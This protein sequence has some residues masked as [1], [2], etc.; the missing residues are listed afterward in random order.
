MT[1]HITTLHH[2]LLSIPMAMTVTSP[3]TPSHL[4]RKRGI[5]QFRACART[6]EWHRSVQGNVVCAPVPNT[7][8]HHSVAGEGHHS[9]DNRACETVVPV[10]VL[11]D[12]EST[13]D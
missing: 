9:P 13:S 12:G 4:S 6:R 5:L 2:T 3:S 8:V 7:R 1:P 10:V 11:V